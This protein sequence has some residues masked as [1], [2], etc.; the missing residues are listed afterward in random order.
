[1]D[2]YLAGRVRPVNGLFGKSCPSVMFP[3]SVSPK[4]LQPQSVAAA[5]RS[6]GD[7]AL[8][9]RT[10][11]RS[12]TRGPAGRSLSTFARSR[13]CTASMHSPNYRRGKPLQGS[14]SEMFPTLRAV[15]WAR[16]GHGLTGPGGSGALAHRDLL[17]LSGRAGN[18]AEVEVGFRVDEHL[19]GLVSP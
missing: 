15:F 7:T 14:R 18:D 10:P 19:A 3:R 4:S 9:R 5:S 13:E 1:M 17:P 6:T 11:R 2:I 16:S 12:F 8:R